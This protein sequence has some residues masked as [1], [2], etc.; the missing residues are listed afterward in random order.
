[1][2]LLHAFGNNLLAEGTPSVWK[3][4][5]GIALA[6]E[7]GGLVI[8]FRSDPINGHYPSYNFNSDTL[9]RLYVHIDDHT[10]ETVNFGFNVRRLW[11]TSCGSGNV[12]SNYNAA[13]ISAGN[14]VYWRL[15]DPSGTIV[16]S[17]SIPAWNGGVT[18]S[19]TTGYI[20]TYGEASNGPDGVD[21]VTTAGYTP[22]N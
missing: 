16:S 15:K 14:V 13:A 6:N 7:S 1:M 2:F 5:S 9:N 20:G 11:F 4:Y 12:N 10:S 3:N 18:T 22:A 19:T 21:G 17:G 8:N